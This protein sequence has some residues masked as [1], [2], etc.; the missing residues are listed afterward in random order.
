[1]SRKTVTAGNRHVCYLTNRNAD[2]AELATNQPKNRSRP[3]PADHNAGGK[4]KAI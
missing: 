1:M 3:L 4:I 2:K